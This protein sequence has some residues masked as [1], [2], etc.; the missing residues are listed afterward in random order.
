MRVLA[1]G[2]VSAALL[3]TLTACGGEEKVAASSVS[4]LTRA[5]L[6][7]TGA[8]RAYEQQNSE[9]PST[10]V[11]QNGELVTGDTV[12]VPAAGQA[13]LAWYRKTAFGYHYCVETEDAHMTVQ[14][15]DG[16]DGDTQ[17]EVESGQCE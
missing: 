4:A 16:G 7:V 2:T 3:A 1:I 17:P 12:R 6:A 5:S 14:G 10:L 11:Q 15:G 8:V 9:H 13:R